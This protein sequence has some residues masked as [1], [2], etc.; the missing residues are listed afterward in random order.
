MTKKQLIANETD[1]SRRSEKG[2][3]PE[4]RKTENLPDGL[5]YFEDEL[6][7]ESVLKANVITCAGWLLE[8]LKLDAGEVSF[9]SET[10]EIRPHFTQLAIFYP[11]FTITR[12]CFKRVKAR[13]KGI[14]GISGL[15]AEFSKKPFVFETD[16]AKTPKN[17]AQIVEILNSSRNARFVD[18]NPKASLL[19]LKAKKLIDEN[20]QIFPSIARIAARLK[21]SHEHLTRQF[22]KDF[23]LSPNAYLHQLRIADATFRLSQGEPIIDVSGDVGYNDLSRFYKQFRKST[24]KSPGFCQTS[25]KVK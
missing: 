1:F 11:P 8:L 24:T 4:R 18:A 15:P 3:L 6:E 22:K 17:A 12:P 10:E 9:F 16:F 25:R 14:A 20:Y 19:S 13:L 23:G 2:D 5:Y 21:V 7:I